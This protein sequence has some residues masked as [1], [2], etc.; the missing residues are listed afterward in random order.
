MRV[1]VG[2]EAG[3][4][5]FIVFDNAADGLEEDDWYFFL[6]GVKTGGFNTGESLSLMI[7]AYEG[8]NERVV[9]GI[10]FLSSSI[11][12]RREKISDC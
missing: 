11:W 10:R 4:E 5:D 6:S 7:W 1:E 3:V 12:R 8:I 2:V 9:S